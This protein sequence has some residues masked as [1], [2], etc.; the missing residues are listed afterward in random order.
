MGSDINGGG[1]GW[2]IDSLVVE[3]GIQSLLHQQRRQRHDLHQGQDLHQH[4]GHAQRRCHA[5]L[6]H[7]YKHSLYAIFFPPKISVKNYMSYK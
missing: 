6:R 5:R 3:R 1:Q 4:R 7:F 2:R